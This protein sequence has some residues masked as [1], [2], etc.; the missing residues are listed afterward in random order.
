MASPWDVVSGVHESLGSKHSSL[1]ELMS[2][3]WNR[4]RDQLRM[5]QPKQA[6]LVGANQNER[7]GY[8]LTVFR[9]RKTGLAGRRPRKQPKRAGGGRGGGRGGGGVQRLV[10]L[11]GGLGARQPKLAGRSQSLKRKNLVEFWLGVGSG[12]GG[13]TP[14]GWPRSQ[15]RGGGVGVGERGRGG[16]VRDPETG[17]GQRMK[18]RQ[19]EVQ[20]SAYAYIIYTYMGGC[21]NYGPFLGTLNTRC[22]IIIGFQKGTVILTTTH[23]PRP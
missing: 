2:K 7:G 20:A 16:G 17:L 19:A 1:F 21:Q 10:W 23:I 22:R 3:G 13:G 15:Q 12:E 14:A 6:G 4:Q 18:P 9:A 11:V 5:L 8:A